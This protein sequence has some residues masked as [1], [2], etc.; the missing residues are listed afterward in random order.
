MIKEKGFTLI[1]LMVVIA[2]IAV[3]TAMIMLGWNTYQRRAEDASVINTMHQLASYAESMRVRDMHYGGV[4]QTEEWNELVNSLPA[5]SPDIEFH[6][7]TDD[8][9]RSDRVYC[10]KTGLSDSG[11]VY[12]VD[13]EFRTGR[14]NEGDVCTATK[15]SCEQ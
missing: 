10:A 15:V 4:D 13:S 8:L 6:T 7:T 5:E 3:L 9:G 1:E 12:C 11:I 14:F 2:I